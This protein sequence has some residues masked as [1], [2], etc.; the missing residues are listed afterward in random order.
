MY[1]MYMQ[2]IY[3]LYIIYVTIKYITDIYPYFCYLFYINQHKHVIGWKMWITDKFWK[4]I[5]KKAMF[6]S[7]F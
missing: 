1:Y 4:E 2:Y 5:W 6:G 7:D 3:V